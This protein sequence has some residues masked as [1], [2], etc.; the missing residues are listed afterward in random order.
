MN[1]LVN[2]ISSI[3]GGGRAYLKNLLGLLTEEFAEKGQHE[4]L[5]L[6]H[7]N[8]ADLLSKVPN[9]NIVWMP[10]QQLNG[11]RRVKWE[12]LNLPRIV[13]ENRIDIQFTPYQV[14]PVMRGVKNVLMIRNMEPFLFDNYTY[15]LK[16]WARNRLLEVISKRCLRRADRVIA[17]SRF[18]ATQLQRMSVPEERF[19]TIYHGSPPLN[20]EMPGNVSS[21]ETL[22]VEGPFIFTCGSI[23][24]YRRI[25]DVIYAFNTCLPALPDNIQLV[26]AG[27][28][29]DLRYARKIRSI[30]ASSPNPSRIL[31]L[32]SVPWEAMVELYRRCEL[33][34]IATEIEA[35]PNIALEAMASGCKI[36]SSDRSPLPEI[37]G[38]CALRYHARDI[39]GLAF[40]IERAVRDIILGEKLKELA[41]ERSQL[42]S[43]SVCSSETYSALTDW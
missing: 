23:L 31:A 38:D 19:R 16:A 34:V 35:C 20:S 7:P 39:N 3:S 30:I 28:G 4:I 24:P 5:F 2:C 43:W 8:Q 18:A 22:G 13:N 10:G 21:I 27:S 41:L 1:V 42:F 26:I 37:L 9:A 25:E 14:A 11:L 33:C 15:S 12:F 17:V 40:Q 6:A 36:V 32:G 29:S